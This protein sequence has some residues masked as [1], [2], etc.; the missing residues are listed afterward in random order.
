MNSITMELMSDLA[1]EFV[2]KKY[3]ENAYGRRYNGC[4]Y[5][6]EDAQDYFNE[7]YGQIETLCENF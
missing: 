6:S 4:V 5:F 7:V 1:T 2:E 3:G